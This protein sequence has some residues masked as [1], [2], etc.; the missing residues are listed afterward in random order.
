MKYFR[1]AFC[2]GLSLL[3]IIF[4]AVPSSAAGMPFSDVNV[5]SWY[6][7]EVE[8]CYENGLMLGTSLT[9]FGPNDEM[10][11]GMLATV[12]YRSAGTPAIKGNLPFSDVPA[13]KYYTK[14]VT[15]AYEQGIV[16]G[17]TPIHF[18]PNRNITREQLVTIFYRYAQANGLK[19]DGKA[20]LTGYADSRAISGYALDA[21]QWAVA[22]GI[23]I[24]TSGTTLSPRSNV[25]RAQCAAVIARYVQWAA[26]QPK[27]GQT[28]GNYTAYYP[29]VMQSVYEYVHTVPEET[30]TRTG[31]GYDYDAA[32]SIR[33]DRCVLRTGIF[34]NGWSEV[35]YNGTRYY[36]QTKDL[37]GNENRATDTLL[38]SEIRSR[39]GMIGRLTIPDV[40]VNVALFYSG[41][42]TELAIKQE[43]VDE[44]DS[45][46]YLEGN[47]QFL[48]GD[49]NYQGFSAMKDS[50]PGETVATIH[51]G[52]YSEQ[53][54]CVDRFTAVNERRD[55]RGTVWD[56]DGNDI[57]DMNAH[58][59]AMYTCNSNSRSVTVT[60]WQKITN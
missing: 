50:V 60:Y 13:S 2:Y 41:I 5:G 43:I 20:G 45:A 8:Y 31:P 23:M 6:S 59:M 53:F 10:S 12:L 21:Y 39:S 17:I 36:V 40:G 47:A 24:G 46:A 25:T 15:W 48:L 28:P 32:E 30:I 29:P 11:R 9:T 18:E 22:E 37:T 51:Y 49:H 55:G 56:S 4:S 42:G 34:N 58:G 35:S 52:T 57:F 7:E 27:T 38:T 44:E 1:K 3:L 14:A 19:A 26:A 16:N 33:Q 54:I